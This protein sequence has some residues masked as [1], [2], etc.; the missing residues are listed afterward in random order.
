MGGS[1]MNWLKKLISFL[2]EL[3]KPKEPDPEPPDPPN[4][5]EP[6]PFD[7]HYTICDLETITGRM[8]AAG[9]NHDNDNALWF[10]L[11]HVYA[12]GPEKVMPDDIVGSLIPINNL[13]WRTKLYNWFDGEVMKIHA[14]MKAN[15]KA[16]A[17]AIVNDGPERCG[18]RLGPPIM[19]RL[20]E[21][22]ERVQKGK[23]YVY[24]A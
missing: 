9:F 10:A 12:L 19:N 6:E 14:L 11:S 20:A 18:F 13:E 17:T 16:T 23:I 15:S 1:G 3:L 24:S 21:F 7:V 5:P 4:P 22:G 2:L 8:R